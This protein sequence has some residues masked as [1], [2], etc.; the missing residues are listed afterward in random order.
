MI[1][2]D[3]MNLFHAAFI[4]LIALST[5][6]SQDSARLVQMARS[7]QAAEAWKLW[8]AM[9]ASVQRT[10]TGVLIAAASGEIGTGLKLYTDL[11][12][13]SRKDEP[14]P[15]RALA[16]S[17][18]RKLTAALPDDVRVGACG[19]V[20]RSK[21][22][23]APCNEL[24][25]SVRAKSGDL[26]AQAVAA[27]RL[28]NAGY[29]PWPELFDTF[30]K[31]LPA[32]TRLTIARS[33]TRLP[34]RDRVELVVPIFDREADV[35]T[36]SA[37]AGV[38][39]DI[40]GAEAFTALK[41]IASREL[42]YTVKLAVSLALARHGDAEGLK[43]VEQLR[44][45]LVGP[46]AVE[47]GIVLA[48]AGNP[49]GA[50]PKRMLEVTN[51]PERARLAL[52]VSQQQPDLAKSAIRGMIADPAPPMREAALRA[53]GI[54]DMGYERVVYSRLEDSDPGV[55]LAAVDAVLQTIGG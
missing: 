46:R 49:Y 24:L 41:R 25:A 4:G 26:S 20:L 22:S 13:Q 11:V 9:P 5:P 18:A 3:T 33:F 2:A 40:R 10:R 23:A 34:P 19:I 12:A 50:D 27:Y 55:R 38:L 43:F 8:Q 48:L 7:G 52:M 35:Q 15:L 21:E 14:E 37:A 1:A 39:G 6:Q 29:R 32:A 31:N 45:G 51:T 36:Q 53:A 47:A 28:A 42:D 54:L 30:E 44:P 16:V 17:T